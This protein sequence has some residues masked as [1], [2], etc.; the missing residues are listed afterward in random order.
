[1]CGSIRDIV[2]ASPSWPNLLPP[3]Q[4]TLPSF[5]TPH[6]WSPPTL[7][8]R[9]DRV[10]W[11]TCPGVAHSSPW[12]SWPSASSARSVEP[13]QRAA[14]STVTPQVV[15]LNEVRSVLMERKTCLPD[16]SVGLAVPRIVP[17]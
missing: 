2:E 5:T 14:P 11:Y 16:T 1:G 10:S 8:D 4:Y 17:R 15:W 9:K 6:T 7:T 12:T 3:Q 13:Q